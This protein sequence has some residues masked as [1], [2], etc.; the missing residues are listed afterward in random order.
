MCCSRRFQIARRRSRPSEPALPETTVTRAASS[1]HQSRLSLPAQRDQLSDVCDRVRE[2]ADRSGF[3]ERTNYACQLAVCEAVENVI[4][5]GYQDGPGGRIDISLRAS[6]GRL[7]VEI[8]DD[9]PPFD[10]THHRV[11]ERFEPS[12]PPVGGR[13]ILM[14]RRVMDDLRYER[15]DDRNILRLTKSGAFHGT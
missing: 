12:D 2:A 11:S 5:H 4:L 9:A 10:P 7:V 15:R 14:I 8:A 13:G 6:P 3:D 1:P